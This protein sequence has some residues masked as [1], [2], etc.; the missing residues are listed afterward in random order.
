M[1]LRALGSTGMRISPVG[2]G[3]VK[4]GRNEGVKYPRGFALPSD[5][6]VVDLLVLARDLGVNFLD[7]APAY[8]TSEE[9]LGRLLPAPRQDWLL[10][11]KVGETF[12]QGQSTF[13]FSAA[14]TRASVARSLKR[15]RTDY[16][17]MVLIHS[18]GDD[19]RI[20]EREAVLDTLLELKTSGVIRAV[21]MSTK[22]P[23]GGLRALQHCDLVMVTLNPA[24]R[25]DLPV[26]AAAARLGR[27]VLVKK[28]LASGHLPHLPGV[29]PIWGALQQVLPV[30]GVSSA[31][32]GTID[33]DH[34]RHNIAVARRVMSD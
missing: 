13:D 9:R 23:G 21:G 17:D 16:L 15:L 24:E 28:A 18:D 4:F 12:Q 2:L 34:L 33:P 19:L 31:V 30:A 29:D 22:T 11:T 25:E 10:A 26:I 27:G 1:E 6:Q 8:G 14:A 3:T 5:R 32:L 20:L 7:T